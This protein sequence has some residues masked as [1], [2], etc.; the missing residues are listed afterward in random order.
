[1]KKLKKQHPHLIVHTHSTKAGIIGRWAAF[2]AGIKKRIHTIHGY[3]FHAH[4]NKILWVSI[5]LIEFI[6]SL[7]TTHYV[8]VSSED[9]KTGIK[10]FPHFSGKHSIIRA[11]VDW[12]QFFIPAHQ[13]AQFPEHKK[14]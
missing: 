4:Q 5:Y 13:V 8:C 12:D 9:V 3:G 10:L 2:F 1:M 6:T 14:R 7:I 11:A